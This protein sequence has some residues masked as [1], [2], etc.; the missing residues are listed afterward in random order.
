M[1]VLLSLC[2]CACA[3]DCAGVCIKSEDWKSKFRKAQ[4]NKRGMTNGDKSP[5][6]DR[7]KHS[8]NHF[9][10]TTFYSRKTT[11]C[12]TVLLQYTVYYGVEMSYL[13]LTILC[14]NKII[15][16]RCKFCKRIFCWLL[17]IWSTLS[18]P[19]PVYSIG[20]CQ[21]KAIYCRLRN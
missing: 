1:Y 20:I 11:L 19:K 4:L 21:V 18:F 3:S 9:I 5:I 14:N 15:K 16:L 13:N 17:L 12:R 6:K 8:N 2:L 10:K 7:W